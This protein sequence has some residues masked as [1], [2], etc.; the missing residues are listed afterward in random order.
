MESKNINENF[1][2]KQKHLTD[3]RK[4]KSHDIC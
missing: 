3:V 1:F 4:E 2:K